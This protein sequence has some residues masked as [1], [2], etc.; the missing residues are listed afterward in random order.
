MNPTQE[1]IETWIAK[2]DGPNAPNAIIEFTV[3]S[4][5]DEPKKFMKRFVVEM[6][7]QIERW[8]LKVDYLFFHPE[9]MNCI[10]SHL[11]DSVIKRAYQQ[12]PLLWGLEL[13]ASESVPDDIIIGVAKRE[14]NRFNIDDGRN[15]A[16][17][18]I[19]SKIV[20]RLNKIKAFW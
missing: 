18:K 16:L 6:M 9:N 2:A 14:E 1:Q 11:G 3:Q 8:D 20:N 13:V 15:I 17:G 4:F 7:I 5:V 10:V 19:D 12:A